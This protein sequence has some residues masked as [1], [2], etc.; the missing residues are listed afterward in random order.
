MAKEA[1]KGVNMV[2]L[3][4]VCVP[5]FT[6]TNSSKSPFCNRLKRKRIKLELKQRRL[7]ID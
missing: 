5:I 2:K 1:R 3:I 6:L 4:A 7:S